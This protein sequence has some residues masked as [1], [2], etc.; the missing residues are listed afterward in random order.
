M[1]EFLEELRRIAQL[2]LNYTRDP[3]DR[4]R[5]ERLLELAA[6]EYES[7]CGLPKETAIERFRRDVG[8]VTPHVGV[9]AAIFDSERRMLL[10]RRSDDGLWAMPG[11]WAELGET[12]QRSTE[13]EVFEEVGLIVEARDIINVTSRLPG[14]YGQPHTSC[15]LLFHCVVT[16]GQLTTTEEAIEAGYHDPESISEWHRDHGERVKA[17][18]RFSRERLGN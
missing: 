18:V 3:F 2:G 17:A 13:R 11:G 8:H 1:T 10:I 16:G 9:D 7:L 14:E 12:P 15:H 4:A 5:Y 6:I